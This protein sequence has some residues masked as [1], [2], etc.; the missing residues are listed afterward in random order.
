MSNLILI[1]FVR[2]QQYILHHS[3]TIALFIESSLF[4]LCYLQ[5]TS[6]HFAKEKPR[7]IFFMLPTFP[8]TFV[9]FPDG[10][11]IINKGEV[12]KVLGAPLP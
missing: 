12:G 8:F 2:L 6:T 1:L 9:T 5:F 11:H 10:K 4:H 3:Q 7:L